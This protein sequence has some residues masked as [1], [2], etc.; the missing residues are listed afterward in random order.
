MFNLD[1]ILTNSEIEKLKITTNLKE[2]SKLINFIGQAFM[3]LPWTYEFLVKSAATHDVEQDIEN[4]LKTI[5]ITSWLCNAASQGKL[6]YNGKAIRFKMDDFLAYHPWSFS[7]PKGYYSMCVESLYLFY[8][9]THGIDSKF[10]SLDQLRVYPAL[11]VNNTVLNGKQ[12]SYIKVKE[13]ICHIV[14]QAFQQCNLC[15]PSPPKLYNPLS[16][17]DVNDWFCLIL[18]TNDTNPVTL[19]DEILEHIAQVQA[20]YQKYASKNKPIRE[21]QPVWINF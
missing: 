3:V 12:S 19:S 16:K 15:L 8:Q 20:V 14:E 21:V 2:E 17:K 13:E 7:S 4:P 18:E 6:T 1:N 11:K 10:L 9:Q 5:V